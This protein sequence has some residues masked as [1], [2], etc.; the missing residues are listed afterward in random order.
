MD[1]FI[2]ELR[3]LCNKHNTVISGRKNK[4]GD[5]PP[6]IILKGDNRTY[7]YCVTPENIIYDK[8]S[9]I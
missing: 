8:D 4:S 5:L 7:V 3:V 2:K 1:D 6:F 9:S